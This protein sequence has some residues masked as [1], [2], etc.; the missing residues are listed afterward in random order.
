MEICQSS[1]G[2]SLPRFALQTLHNRASPVERGLSVVREYLRAGVAFLPKEQE[3]NKR[4]GSMER[5]RC[6]SLL[7]LALRLETLCGKYRC[8]RIVNLEAD[9]SIGSLD[10]ARAARC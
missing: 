8:A 5:K 2:I 10:R 7:T 3:A 4:V 9:H 1:Q 6:S